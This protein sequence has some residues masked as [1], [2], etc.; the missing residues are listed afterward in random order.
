MEDRQRRKSRVPERDYQDIRSV[1]LAQLCDVGLSSV[2]SRSISW[3]QLWSALTEGD[4][5]RSSIWPTP[6][7]VSGCVQTTSQ[8]GP[9]TDGSAED[10]FKAW[11]VADVVAQ[12]EIV[13]LRLRT[14]PVIAETI[15]RSFTRSGARRSWLRSIE[16]GALEVFA[17]ACEQ[18]DPV[19]GVERLAVCRF[20][21]LYGTGIGWHLKDDRDLL[22]QVVSYQR[23]WRRMFDAYDRRLEWQLRRFLNALGAIEDSY[24]A[25]V[26]NYQGDDADAFR[27]ATAREFALSVVALTRGATAPMGV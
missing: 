13:D 6:D 2:V 26:A 1:A 12:L 19:Y 24:L 15:E 20:R 25:V 27:E 3:R 14:A 22:A 11:F 21:T 7:T 5:I 10:R 23:V 8:L 18:L 16:R 17:I 4:S 9:P